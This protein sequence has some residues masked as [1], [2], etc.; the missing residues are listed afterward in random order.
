[1][2]I[3]AMEAARMGHLGVELHTPEEYGR[4]E[5]V[6][7]KLSLDVIR[8]EVVTR[9]VRA[10]GIGSALTPWQFPLELADHLRAE[11]VEL[12]A[13]RDH[14]AARRRAKNEAELAGIRRAQGAADAAMA[15][16]RELLRD[17]AGPPTCERI[18]QELDHLVSEH[19]CT[20]EIA[21]VSHG[22]QTAIGHELGSGPIERGEPVMSTSRRA[23]ARPAATP[24]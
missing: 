24:T 3:H 8:R 19:D 5:L 6:K 15:R 9:A 21:I 17:P 13:D 4:D 18:K 10:W 14:F 7:Q 16:V 2:L 1:V 11:G 22:P 20:L 23:T 12:H